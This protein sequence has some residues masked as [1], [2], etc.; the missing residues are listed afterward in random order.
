MNIFSFFF[1]FFLVFYTVL[2][3][4]DNNFS[5]YKVKRETIVSNNDCQNIKSILEPF[6]INVNNCCEDNRIT[7]DG[8]GRITEM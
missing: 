3:N 7:C 4:P 8:N 5:I 2:A 1:N 6:E